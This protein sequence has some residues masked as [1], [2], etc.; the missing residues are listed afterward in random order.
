MN[1]VS[2]GKAARMLS[3]TPDTVLKWIKSGKLKARR[4]AGGHY[5][6]PLDAIHELLSPGSD[7][8]VAKSAQAEEEAVP[9]W[10]FHAVAGKVR[11]EC[12]SCLVFKSGGDRCYEVGRILKGKGSGATCCP[13]SC[14]EC[15]YYIHRKQQPVNVLVFTD[16]EELRQSLKRDSIQSRLRLQFTSCEYDCSLIVD[17]FRPECVVVDCAME[18]SVCEELCQHLAQDP[19]IPGVRIVLAIPWHA[20]CETKLKDDNIIVVEQPLRLADLENRLANSI[21]AEGCGR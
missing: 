7:L 6:I 1:H 19:R 20:Q 9:C 2:T 14:E 10:E 11:D 13:L 15:S 16:N 4:T 3:V 21:P 18:L 5:R 8:S 17:S 12:H